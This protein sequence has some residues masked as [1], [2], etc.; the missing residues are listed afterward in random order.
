MQFS[1]IPRILFEEILHLCSISVF[2]NLHSLLGRLR[3]WAVNS[4]L[5]SLRRKGLGTK[6]NNWLF[7][8]FVLLVVVVGFVLLAPF[9]WSASLSVEGC[10][11]VTTCPQVRDWVICALPAISRVKEDP[12]STTVKAEVKTDFSLVQVSL[13]FRH[14]RILLRV[15]GF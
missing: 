10:T 1:V 3:C 2:Q 4:A 8:L 15:R 5:T 7:V 9:T 12:F 14:A 6:K 13:A 11:G